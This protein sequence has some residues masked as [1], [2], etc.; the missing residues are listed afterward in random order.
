MY[1][2]SEKEQEDTRKGKKIVKAQIEQNQFKSRIRTSPGTSSIL[3]RGKICLINF[4]SLK[5]KF[6]A[7]FG[8][9][10]LSFH[11]APKKSEERKGKEKEEVK[12]QLEMDSVR[13]QRGDSLYSI[14]MNSS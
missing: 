4:S 3:R 14:K 1:Y 11:F 2:T 12:E 8:G 13:T 6:V 5:S 7:E 10:D 9:T